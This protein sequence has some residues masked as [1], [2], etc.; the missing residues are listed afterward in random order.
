MVQGVFEYG[1]YEYV[2]FKVIRGQSQGQNSRSF[3]PINN[4][5]FEVLK[6]AKSCNDRYYYLFILKDMILKFKK[7]KKKKSNWQPQQWPQL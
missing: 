1:K 3:W 5:Y 2:S 4:P 6:F 7:K